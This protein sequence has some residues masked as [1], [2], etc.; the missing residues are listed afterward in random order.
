M[1]TRECPLSGLSDLIFFTDYGT[2]MAAVIKYYVGPSIPKHMI[3]ERSFMV[4]CFNALFWAEDE[5]ERDLILFAML[6]LSYAHPES[7]LFK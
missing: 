5:V 2:F 1:T 7:G 4:D 6:V 3:S